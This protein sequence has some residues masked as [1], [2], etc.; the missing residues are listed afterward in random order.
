MTQQIETSVRRT[1]TVAARRER[2]FDVFTAGFGTWWPKAHHIGAAELAAVTLEPRAGGRWFETGTDGVECDWGRVLAWEPPNRVVCS[3][4]LQGDWRYDPDPAKGSEV[5]V[6]FI[7]EG[8]DR[9]RVE[10]EHRHFERHGA[11]AESVRT[12]VDNPDGWTH[13]LE[14]FVERVDAA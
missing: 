8:P 5:E 7:A 14:L 11:G 2:A 12:G 4:Q 9:T 13:I 10:V 1:V 3:W 6:R